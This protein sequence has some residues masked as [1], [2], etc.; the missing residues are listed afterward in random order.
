MLSRRH[1]LLAAAAAPLCAAKMTAKERVRRA[2]EGRDVDR[3]PFSFWHHFGLEKYP[4]Q[5]HAQA[6]LE[7][8]RKFRTDLV[9]VMSDYPYPKPAG[10]WYELKFEPNPFP[11]QIRALE[12]INA[13]LAGE[14]YFVETLFNPWQVAGKLSSEKEVLRLKEEKPQVLLD[15]LEVIARSQASHAKKAVAAGA[16]GIFLSITNA[17][18]GYQTRAEYAKFGEPFDR[19]IFEAVSAAPLNTLHLH[20]D[21]VYLDLF[22]KGWPAAAI[23]YSA[24]GTGVGVAQVRRHY[25]GLLMAGLDERNYRSLDAADLRTQWKTAQQAAGKKFVLTPGCSVPNDSTDAELMRLVNL[26]GA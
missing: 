21:K 4:G 17:N 12:L 23:N 25:G 8:H 26:L 22:Y 20:G 1:F 10:K 7:F 5:R 2:L 14:A 16:A 11:E 9:K 15:A 3:V 18:E 13:G 6:T 19:M 24:H